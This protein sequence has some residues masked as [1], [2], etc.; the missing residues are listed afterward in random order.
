[1]FENSHDNKDITSID[2]PRYY[3]VMK[4]NNEAKIKDEYTTINSFSESLDK[5]CIASRS[6]EKLNRYCNISPFDDNRVVLEGG[7]F[8]NEYI[9]ASFVDVRSLF[10]LKLLLSAENLLRRAITLTTSI[11]RLKDLCQQPLTIS[12]A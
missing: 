7:E 12:G 5:T 8:E 4:E 3:N 10:K 6:N 11:L 2:F 1:M 9:N